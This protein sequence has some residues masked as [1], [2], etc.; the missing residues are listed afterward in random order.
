MADATNRVD[1]TTDTR[2]FKILELAT[3]GWSLVERN[4]QNLTRKECDRI[5]NALVNEGIA[6]DRLKVALQDDPR[7]PTDDP[8]FKVPEV[9]TNLD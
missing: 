3:Q 2:K 9:P 1:P 6:P 4:Y 7:Y 5:L 8:G